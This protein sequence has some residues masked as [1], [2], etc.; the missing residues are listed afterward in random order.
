MR[1]LL[2]LILFLFPV[3]IQAQT[4]GKKAVIILSTNDTLNGFVDDKEW[5]INPAVIDELVVGIVLTFV[6]ERCSSIQS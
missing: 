6:Y 4:G 3:N 1:K 2:P 5:L